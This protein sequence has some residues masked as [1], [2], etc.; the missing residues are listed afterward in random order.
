M[1]QTLNMIM[2]WQDA[3]K[4][5]E[6]A[7]RAANTAKCNLTNAVNA[8]GKRMLPKDA[9]KGVHGGAEK[10]CVWVTVTEGEEQL[11]TVTKAGRI[12]DGDYDI[13]FQGERRNI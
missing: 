5:K 6:D 9:Q 8:L 11:L 3:K 10:V 7:D 1:S 4:S 2:S 13:E 12:S